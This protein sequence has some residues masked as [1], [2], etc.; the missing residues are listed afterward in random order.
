MRPF[1]HQEALDGSKH[2]RLLYEQ[3]QPY[4]NSIAK[5]IYLMA[6]A[7]SYRENS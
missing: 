4:R 2:I 7:R 1:S 5:T 6:L 3:G